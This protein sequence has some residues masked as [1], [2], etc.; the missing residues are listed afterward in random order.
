MAVKALAING[1]LELKS[2]L[3]RDRR[4]TIPLALDSLS[5]KAIKF[6]LVYQVSPARQHV[7]TEQKHGLDEVGFYFAVRH[8][9][10]SV[11]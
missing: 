1:Y 3:F 9:G 5:A 2:L 11:H 7:G 10:T 6:Q 8:P 4:W